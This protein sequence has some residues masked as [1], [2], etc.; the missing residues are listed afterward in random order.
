M[1]T[2]SVQSPADGARRGRNSR[3]VEPTSSPTS[4]ASTIRATARAA[5]RCCGRSPGFTRFARSRVI[6]KGLP[7]IGRQAEGG[8]ED[9]PAPLALAP[10][11]DDRQVDGHAA[12]L[13]GSGVDV[14][15]KA[16]AR[17]PSG[18]VLEG[19]VLAAVVIFALTYVAV[20]A[21]RIPGLSVDRPSAALL[22]AVLMVAAGVLTP[23]EG[24]RAV[25]GDTL[26]L[27]LGTMI[28][29]AYLGE[30]GFFRWASGWI[31]RAF[32]GAARAPVGDRLH[33]GRA[34]GAPRERHRL[35]DAD[36]ARHPARGRRRA[37]CRCRTSSPSRS[38]RT[39]GASRRSPGTRRT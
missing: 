30:A 35:P 28:L 3:R 32:A 29:S 25:N 17:R 10:V 39:R 18:G 13:V 37:A 16:R 22:G 5:S 27:L 21:G 23:A 2:S 12:N 14:G 38:A 6:V 8:A 36:A 7:V 33:G 4:S 20:A 24:G 31:L 11:E 9:L 1:P 15:E 19:A 26:G 34:L